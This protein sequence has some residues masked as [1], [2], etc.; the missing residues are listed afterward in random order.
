MITGRRQIS[1]L[2]YKHAQGGELGT[3]GQ[4]LVVVKAVA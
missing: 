1:W 2:I 3:I 4:I